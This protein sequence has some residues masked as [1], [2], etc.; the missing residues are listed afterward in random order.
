MNLPDAPITHQGL[1]ATHFFTVSDQE[2]SLADKA[3]CDLKT[4]SP[5][6]RAGLGKI[7]SRY[8]ICQT[9]SL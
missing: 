2:K 9:R 4:K 5:A 3:A 8:A 7:A 6:S 1:F